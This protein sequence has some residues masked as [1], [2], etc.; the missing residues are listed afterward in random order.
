MRKP[1]ADV[2]RAPVGKTG[3]PPTPEAPD[4]Q[5][6]DWNTIDLG[7]LRLEQRTMLF[8]HTM[9]DFVAACE[10]LTEYREAALPPRSEV[11]VPQRYRDIA[12]RLLPLVVSFGFGRIVTRE[13]LREG[14]RVFRPIFELERRQLLPWQE[15]LLLAFESYRIPVLDGYPVGRRADVNAVQ[16]I[17]ED[18]CTH[19]GVESLPDA[20]CLPWRDAEL[21]KKRL[22][23]FRE[24]VP[25]LR[26]MRLAKPGER[27]G[28]RAK[29][30]SAFAGAREFAQLLGLPF[31]ERESDLRRSTKSGR[32]TRT[33][34]KPHR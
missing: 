25:A 2:T 28:G 15:G 21:R 4:G 5:A 19:A 3:S 10:R 6:S 7:D 26:N 8:R 22:A 27:P 1:K 31:P 16:S 29:K 20:M 23:I 17:I 13:E 30:L 24:A 33:A 12:R 14:E 9:A 32:R 18:V 34:P 11:E